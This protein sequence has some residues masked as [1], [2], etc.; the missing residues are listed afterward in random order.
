MEGKDNNIYVVDIRGLVCPYT[1][2]KAKLALEELKI[3]DILEI[4]LDNIAA[5]RNLPTAFIYYGQ[6]YLGTEA[7]SDSEWII[8]IRKKE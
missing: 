2:I 8:K 1:L 4:H 6:E 3:G 5:L 7:I